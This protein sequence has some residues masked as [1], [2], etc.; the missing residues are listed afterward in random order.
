MKERTTW[1]GKGRRWRMER[2]QLARLFQT[3][4]HPSRPSSLSER[5]VPA[6]DDSRAEIHD[7]NE[8][9]LIWCQTCPHPRPQS[10]GKEVRFGASWDRNV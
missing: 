7:E 6:L 1:R 4:L 3:P 10:S 8:G 5:D 9:S 2:G